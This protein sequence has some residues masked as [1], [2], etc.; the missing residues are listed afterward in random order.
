MHA[1]YQTM[2]QSHFFY[3]EDKMDTDN[4]KRKEEKKT[5]T[6]NEFNT[7]SLCSFLR[8][9]SFFFFV[10]KR[11]L[12]KNSKQSQSTTTTKLNKNE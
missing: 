12:H 11:P 5:N 6:K 3:V 8:L 4:K 10:N 7:F 1:N 9:Y 2:F